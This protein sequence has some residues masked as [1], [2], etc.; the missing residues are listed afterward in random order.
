MRNSC[1]H[2]AQR[3]TDAIVAER[4]QPACGPGGLR[5]VHERRQ[6][7][8]QDR[9]VGV[10]EGEVPTAKVG[11]F[12]ASGPMRTAPFLALSHNGFAGRGSSVSSLASA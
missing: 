8:E 12:L 4:S 3:G 2:G 1:V 9:G 10:V 11:F 5:D 6:D 7:I